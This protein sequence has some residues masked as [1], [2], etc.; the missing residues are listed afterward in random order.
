[1]KGDDKTQNERTEN[2]IPERPGEI[3]N[4]SCVTKCRIFFA[5]YTQK[6]RA[7]LAPHADPGVGSTYGTP[8]RTPDIMRMTFSDY[9]LLLVRLSLCSDNQMYSEI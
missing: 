1:M 9:E 2:V 6:R 8:G 5:F 4:K 7:F 3:S